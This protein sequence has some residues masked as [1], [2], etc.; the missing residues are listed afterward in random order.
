[1][2]T[3]RVSFSVQNVSLVSESN[4]SWRVI[5]WNNQGDLS[6]S[7]T[8]SPLPA[9]SPWSWEWPLTRFDPANQPTPGRLHV[10]GQASQPSHSRYLARFLSLC[11]QRFHQRIVTIF[12]AL[13]FDRFRSLTIVSDSEKEHK[14]KPDDQR[15]PKELVATRCSP[16]EPGSENA[17]M[18]RKWI[19]Q[20]WRCV[21]KGLGSW[22]TELKQRIW[23]N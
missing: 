22:T 5:V 6:P 2:W 1:M 19:A 17:D 18:L 11:F 23:K 15:R 13:S 21:V 20:R 9:C 12:L 10:K 14:K 4:D 7:Q 8:S 16:N 3:F